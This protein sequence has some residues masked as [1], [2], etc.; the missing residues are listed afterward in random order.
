MKR[1][2]KY[3]ARATIAR[4]QPG[5]RTLEE[6]ATLL[7]T[8]KTNACQILNKGLRKLAEDLLFMHNGKKPTSEEIKLLAADP[9]FQQYVA[10]GLKKR[11]RNERS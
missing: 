10:D 4:H 2:K 1:P 11:G 6:V 8:T 7:N 9:Y 5:W 3:V